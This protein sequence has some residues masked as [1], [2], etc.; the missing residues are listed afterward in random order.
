MQVA[1][2]MNAFKVTDII[3][4]ALAKLTT[5]VFYRMI[6]LRN[7]ANFTEKHLALNRSLV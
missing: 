3:T 6:V 1:Q 4:G 5:E 7:F 2:V